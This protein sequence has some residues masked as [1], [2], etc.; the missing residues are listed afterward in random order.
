MPAFRGDLAHRWLKGSRWALR[1]NRPA[2]SAPDR[3][4]SASD[5]L[6][7]LKQV[8]FTG[9][10]DTGASLRYLERSACRV[11]SEPMHHGRASRSPS[12]MTTA[13]KTT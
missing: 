1:F 13:S 5:T 7:I 10:W 3:C 9:V 11:P 8:R 4:L 12:S 2:L 6:A